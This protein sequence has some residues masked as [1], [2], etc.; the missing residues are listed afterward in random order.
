MSELFN[1]DDYGVEGLIIAC[2]AITQKERREAPKK[3]LKHN[4]YRDGRRDYSDDIIIN[5]AKVWSQ[6]QHTRQE[7]AK[8]LGVSPQLV[9]VIISGR[10]YKELTKEILKFED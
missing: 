6:G 8:H 4:I 10:R 7:L 3:S 2:T 5:V 1:I 9:T